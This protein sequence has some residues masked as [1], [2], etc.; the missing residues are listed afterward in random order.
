MPILCDVAQ[1]CTYF[2]KRFHCVH[3]RRNISKRNLLDLVS[4]LVLLRFVV[5][6]QNHSD[7]FVAKL[8]VAVLKRNFSAIYFTFLTE[9]SPRMHRH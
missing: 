1:H 9:K 3:S 7:Y 2:K 8:L 6:E 4:N 5:R